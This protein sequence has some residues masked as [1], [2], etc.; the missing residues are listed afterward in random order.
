MTR[1]DVRRIVRWWTG[2]TLDEALRELV[3]CGEVLAVGRRHFITVKSWTGPIGL[4][5]EQR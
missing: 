2:E 5:S 4:W 3:A 1:D